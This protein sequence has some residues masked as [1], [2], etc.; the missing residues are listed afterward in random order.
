MHAS[1]PAKR[2]PK[3]LG[4]DAKLFGAYTLTDVAVALLPAVVVILATQ[5]LLPTGTTVAGQPVQTLALPVA[6]LAGLGGVAFVYLTPA[7]ASSLDWLLTIVGFHRSERE[8][9]HEAAREVTHLERVYPDRDAIER[10]DGTVVGLV[11]VEPPLNALATDAEW[12]RQAEAFQDFCNTTV[13]FPIQIY[14]TTQAFPVG[15]YLA[16]YEARLEDP[17]VQAN[18]RLAT[19]IEEYREWYR[20]DLAERRMTIRD[21]YVIVPV[22]PGDVQ[23]DDDSVADS[24]AGL[25]VVGALV[26]AWRAP[27]RAVEREAQLAALDER[28]RQVEGGLRDLEGC[29]AS[30]VDAAQATRLLAEFWTGEPREGRDLEAALRP[31][32]V[33]GGPR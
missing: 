22:A 20:A 5:V 11:Q 4:T 29:D 32:P 6:A 27:P 28:L 21:H 17:D 9:G 7:Y 26:R 2:I 16:H 3:S 10:T 1:D 25:P 14:S 24:L 33:V 19:L 23:F 31:T 8:L 12:Q 13:E 30:R 15:D 18:P